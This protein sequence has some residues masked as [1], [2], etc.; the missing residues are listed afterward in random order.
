M[1]FQEWQG[2]AQSVNARANRVEAMILE[3]ARRTCRAAGLDSNLL[4]IH[5]HN[6]MASFN[7][8]HP[9]PEVNYSL[10]RKTLWLIEKSFEP[11]RIADRVI[12]R[13]WQKHIGR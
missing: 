7:S 11:H 12:A 13:A 6:A 4:G 2:F 1:T 10:C 3:D 5:P 9:W 8:G